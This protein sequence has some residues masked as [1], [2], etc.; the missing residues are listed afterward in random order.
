[1][2][3]TLML[4]ALGG[5]VGSV[6]RHLVSKAVYKWFPTFIP[7]GTFV[8]NVLGCFVIGLLYGLALRNTSCQGDIKVLL[9]TGLC[10]GF[11]TFSAFALENVSLLQSGEYMQAAL[12][13]S[14]SVVMG[15]LAVFGGIIVM[16]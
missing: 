11:T 2:L 9:M 14:A 8:V 13:I 6:L 15:V 7:V 16:R 12:Y 3:R 1:M 4:V 10:G 5:G